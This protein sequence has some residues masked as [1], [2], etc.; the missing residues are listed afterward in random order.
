M[1]ISL[2]RSPIA[3]DPEFDQGEHYFTYSILPFAGHFGDSGVIRS[4]YELNSPAEALFIPVSQIDDPNDDN[5]QSFCAVDGNQVI[6]ESVKAPED[7]TSGELIL[8]LYECL[9]GKCRTTL[10]FHRALRAAARTDMLEENPQILP[11]QGCDIDLEFRPF[12]IKTIR[13]E[14]Y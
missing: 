11:V 3:P 9:G 4:A 12:E 14:Y 5:A 6:I 8:R 10:H 13:V 2:L 1:R 7:K